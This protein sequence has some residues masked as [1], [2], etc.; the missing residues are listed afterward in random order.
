MGTQHFFQ[1]P[2]CQCAIQMPQRFVGKKRD[3]VWQKPETSGFLKVREIEARAYGQERKER[4]TPNRLVQALWEI[5]RLQLKLL[6]GTC[7]L[8]L[9]F[10][11]SEARNL[12]IQRLRGDSESFGGPVLAG[13]SSS[14]G[15]Q[16]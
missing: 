11:D 16:S 1:L 13:H 5:P 10:I 15:F 8:Q 14:R 12:G 3:G 6:L 7:G 9:A 4:V 2:L